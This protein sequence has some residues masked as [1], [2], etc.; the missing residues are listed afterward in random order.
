M[1]VCVCGRGGEESQACV[2]ALPCCARATKHTK[3]SLFVGKHAAAAPHARRGGTGRQRARGGGEIKHAYPGVG[4]RCAGDGARRAATRRTPTSLFLS[5]ASRA[6]TCTRHLRLDH[7]EPLAQRVM[8]RRGRV[9][10]LFVREV[11]EDA[12]CGTESEHGGAGRCWSASAEAGH[13]RTC[14]RSAEAAR[15]PSPHTPREGEREQERR[16][17]APSV[18]KGALRLAM[19]ACRASV[20]VLP[21]TDF[22]DRLSQ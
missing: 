8:A 9:C 5:S 15:A 7:R 13:A 2:S 11:A 1:C 10:L 19:V 17:A 6:R 12:V 3:G 18:A 14:L 16:C 22:A 21:T 20:C 4:C